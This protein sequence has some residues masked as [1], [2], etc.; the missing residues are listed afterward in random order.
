MEIWETIGYG[1]SFDLKI[2]TAK[3]VVRRNPKSGKKS[4]FIILDSPNWVNIIPVTKNNEVVLVRQYRHGINE[5]TLEIPGGLIDKDE[6][7]IE[8]AK[9]EC[10]EETGFWSNDEPILLGKVRPNP[11][12]QTNTCYTYLWTNVE[13]RFEPY[14]DTNEVIEVVLTSAEDLEKLIRTGKIDHSI[15]LNALLFYFLHSKQT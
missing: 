2:F 13:K 11:A 7:P 10:K 15:V 5:I 3:W 9:R 4:N 8:A 6:T 14:L 12:F 1:E